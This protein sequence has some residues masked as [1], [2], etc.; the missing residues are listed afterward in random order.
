MDKAGENK[1]KWTKKAKIREKRNRKKNRRNKIMKR[2]RG[3]VKEDKG[4]KR[5]IEEQNN[6]KEGEG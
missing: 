6:R 3:Q 2:R 5:G 4:D 1:G